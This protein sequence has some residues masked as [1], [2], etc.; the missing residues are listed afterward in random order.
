MSRTFRRKGFEK[1]R[2][3]QFGCKLNGYYTDMQWNGNQPVAALMSGVE[4]RK[5]YWIIHGESKHNQAWGFNKWSRRY[6][7]RIA[8]TQN[9]K[10]LFKWMNNND[11][12]PQLS[13]AKRTMRYD[14]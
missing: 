10:E 3:N 11:H 9:K 6:A 2:K 8:K 12:E 4:Y 14:W 1:T 13:Q 7:N 5:A